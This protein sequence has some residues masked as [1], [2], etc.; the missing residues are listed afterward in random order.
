LNSPDEVALMDRPSH[1]LDTPLDDVVIAYECEGPIP[2]S[3]ET[4]VR[5]ALDDP[6]AKWELHDGLLVEKPGM[7]ITHLS[8]V[9][10]LGT[11][12][13]Q[14]I[15]LLHFRVLTNAGRL[16]RS[17]RNYLIPDVSVVRSELVRQLRQAQPMGLAVF[18]EPLL[19]VAEGWF[20]STE[21]YD[22]QTKIPTYKLRGGQEIWR[23]H[24]F[25]RTVTAW[26][27]RP[28][29]EYDQIEFTGGKVNL[30]ALPHVVVDLDVL[31]A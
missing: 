1:V 17:A 25:E 10:L 24:P 19:F 15:D 26:R 23:V 8:V 14:Q 5:L 13:A 20:L 6:Q 9:S 27:R 29:G 7:N 3:E 21:R 31:F 4:F 12:L 16:R 18:D 22:V 28:D 2:V 30:H 11:L